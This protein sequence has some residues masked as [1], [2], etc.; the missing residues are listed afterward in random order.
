MPVESREAGI[1]SLDVSSAERCRFASRRTASGMLSPLSK[2]M[3]PGVGVLTRRRFGT[4]AHDEAMD[5][6]NAR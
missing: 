5:E 2:S 6:R 4:K 3:I 1:L